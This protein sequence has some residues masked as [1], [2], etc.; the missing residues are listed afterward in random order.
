[1]TDKTSISTETPDQLFR[2]TQDRTA[3]QSPDN[4]P[5]EKMRSQAETGTS[6]KGMPTGTPVAG[7]GQLGSSE[8]QVRDAN[9]QAS[10]SLPH[11]RDQWTDM[12][13]DTPDPIMEQASRDV[14]K[15]RQDTS[16][17]QE[18]DQTYEKFR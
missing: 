3:A 4:T 11:E 5:N 8:P 6:G 10:K 12:T 2:R 9:E 16:K 7:G 17:G 14:S 15:G 18:T 1:M 13:R